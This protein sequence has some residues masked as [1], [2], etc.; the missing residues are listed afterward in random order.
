[1]LFVGVNNSNSIFL[2]L[3]FPQG[4]SQAKQISHPLPD[5][6]NF[7]NVSRA[8]G[9]P[10][11][12]HSDRHKFCPEW[13]YSGERCCVQVKNCLFIAKLLEHFKCAVAVVETESWLKQLLGLNML[14]RVKKCNKNNW[15]NEVNI[16][17]NMKQ[18]RNLLWPLFFRGSVATQ[19][20]CWRTWP[21]LGMPSPKD[22]WFSAGESTTMTTRT[23]GS[24]ESKGLTGL[25]MIGMQIWKACLW[26]PCHYLYV[27]QLIQSSLISLFTAPD[28]SDTHFQVLCNNWLTFRF[29]LTIN[30]CSSG[31]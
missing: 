10:V 19:R 20:S 22:W 25:S 18:D 24:W 29:Y 27:G 28:K 5:S 31:K 26:L 16:Q 1:M 6:G 9:H 7:W 4:A 13:E 3:C 12:D 8:D 17:D 23:E 14:L 30:Y 21:T 11:P 15:K 2:F